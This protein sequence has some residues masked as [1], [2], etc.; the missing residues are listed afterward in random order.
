MLSDSR[1]HCLNSQ[2]RTRGRIRIIHWLVYVCVCVCLL[3]FIILT[4]SIRRE[5]RCFSA[6]ISFWTPYIV[7]NFVGLFRLERIMCFDPSQAD[8]QS[9][10]DSAR[11]LWMWERQ[12][13]RE[14]EREKPFSSSLNSY[15]FES[16]SCPSGV[17]Y[18]RIYVQAHYVTIGTLSCSAL[19]WNNSRALS[20]KVPL[21]LK[22]RTETSTGEDRHAWIHYWESASI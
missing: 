4:I 20:S 7:V 15:S 12:K 10:C 19:L 13:M 2:Q 22:W 17:V 21:E 11:M 8:C 3:L 5:V 18:V 9:T 6:L 16:D 1:H 14:R